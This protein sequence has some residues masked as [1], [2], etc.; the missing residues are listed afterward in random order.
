M[1]A[2]RRIAGHEEL[3]G[4]MCHFKKVDRALHPADALSAL[5]VELPGEDTPLRCGGIVVVE[6]GETEEMTMRPSTLF[7]V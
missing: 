1:R 6:N 7:C 3:Y 4:R 5:C 2:L